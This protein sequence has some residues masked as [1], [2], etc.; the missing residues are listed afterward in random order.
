MPNIDFQ[1]LFE[2]SPNPYMVLDRELRYVAANTAYL[3]TVGKRLED[4]LGTYVLDAF[5]HDAEDPSNAN[6]QLLRVSFERV[7]ATGQG[8][9]IAL[10]AYRVPTRIGDQI[11]LRERYWSATH[12]PIVDADGRV[13]YV[14]QHTVDVTEVQALQHRLDV[15]NREALRRVEDAATAS[16]LEQLHAGLLQRTDHVQA[17]NLSLDSER[18]HLRNLFDQT[19]GF[20]AFLRGK[21][22]VFEL[23]NPAYHQVIGRRDII[24][25][26][27]REALPE[28]ARQGYVDLLDTVYATATPFVGRGMRTQIQREPGGPLAEMLL[29]VVYQPIVGPEGKVTGIFVQGHDMTAQR[30]AERDRERLVTIVEQSTDCVSVTGLD[31]RLTYL[32][33]TGQRLLGLPADRICVTASDDFFMPEDLP[34]VSETIHP[35]L[36]AKGR[37]EGV[38]RFRHFQTGEPVA[39]HYNAFTILDP[40]TGEIEA[41]AS[42]SRDLREKQAQEQEIAV[43]FAAEQAA[44][45]AIHATQV[46]H[47]F[48]ADAIPDQVWT[49][50]PDGGLSHVN[51]RVTTYFALTAE[52]IIGAGWQAVVHPDDS[53]NFVA[54]WTLALSTGQPYEC[55]F[56]LLRGSDQSYRWHMARALS[57]RDATG[58]IVKWYGSNTDIDDLKRT[59]R[60]RDEL[61]VALSASNLELDQ[62][63]YVASHDLKAPLRGISN[64]AQWIQEDLGETVNQETREHLTM[65]QRRVMRLDALIDGVLDYARAGRSK[66]GVSEVDV[67]LMLAEVIELLAPKATVRIEIGTAMPRLHGVAVALQQV[68]MNLIGNALKHSR[69][70]DVVV[71]IAVQERRTSSPA[72]R[73]MYRFSVSDNGP[74]IEPRFHE[75]IW[76]LFQVLQP[77]DEVEGSGIGLSVAKKLVEARGGQVGVESELGQGATFWFTWPAWSS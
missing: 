5:P 13:T 64:L 48:L 77:R 68:F 73:T 44:R 66:G 67:N 52:E 41:F 40:A 42:V 1:A 34:F 31:G 19:P 55:E 37:W 57:L 15:A 74:G 7:I 29:D 62:F 10:L 46:E 56:R 22:H 58:K 12:T 65:M 63:A 21:D 76:G 75:R 36:L 27:V 50:A 14:L 25:R 23:A 30:N 51:R 28:V 4:L 6:A 33:E 16:P 26:P 38:H 54:L 43:L 49:A 18:R 11:E 32:N 9:T 3:A 8:D 39:I 20:V 61:I 47:S 60:E 53:A 59:E 45:A 72:G 69:R 17:A 70:D 71:R 24:G 35:V 2:R